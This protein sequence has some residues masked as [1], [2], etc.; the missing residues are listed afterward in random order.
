MAHQPLP[1]AVVFNGCTPTDGF[2]Y[3]T[4]LPEN[5]GQ[6]QGLHTLWSMW[7]A[8][9]D[10]GDILALIHDD[11]HLLQKGWDDA[12]RAVMAD[13]NVLLTGFGGATGLSLK[14]NHLHRQDF[15]SNLVD[16][17][18]HGRRIDVP[19]RVA[20][21]D[22]FAM[23]ARLTF[24]DDLGGFEWWPFPYHCID[25]ALSLEVM[26][27]GAQTWVVPVRCAHLSGRTANSGAYAAL[28]ARYGGTDAVLRNGLRKLYDDYHDVLPGKRSIIDYIYGR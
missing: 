23:I 26:R 22:S 3:A 20:V 12:I 19:A 5:V 13:P 25:Y 24:L 27:R 7:E 6:V 28:A 17:E 14:P 9:H 10:P 2:D 1:V 18:I 16:A 21:L 8:P 11:V 15:V 4:A